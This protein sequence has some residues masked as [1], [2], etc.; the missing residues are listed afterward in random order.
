MTKHHRGAQL[1]QVLLQ[2]GQLPLQHLQRGDFCGKAGRAREGTVEGGLWGMGGG[3]GLASKALSSG[4]LTTL[5]CRGNPDIRPVFCH[6]QNG[7]RAS[8]PNVLWLLSEADGNIGL[9]AFCKAP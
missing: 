9:K 5:Y 2:P 4:P 3:A 7:T 6:L 8:C 1:G